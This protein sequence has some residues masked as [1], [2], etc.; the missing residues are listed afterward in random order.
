M[1]DAL[2]VPPRQGPCERCQQPRP[3]FAWPTPDSDDR[4]WLCAP[5]WSMFQEARDAG[6]FVDWNDAFDNATDEQLAEGLSGGAR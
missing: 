2:L 4:K 1:S 5:C 3:T 6:T